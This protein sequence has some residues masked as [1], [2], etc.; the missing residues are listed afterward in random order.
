MKVEPCTE[1][2]FLNFSFRQFVLDD[3]HL[4]NSRDL[5]TIKIKIS[6]GS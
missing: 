1:E 3:G 5:S 2:Y 4:S 6:L